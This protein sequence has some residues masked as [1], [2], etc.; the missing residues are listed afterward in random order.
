MNTTLAPIPDPG[1]S[2]GNV[3]AI[4]VLVFALAILYVHEQSGY[5]T[6]INETT[7]IQI[8][9]PLLIT[10]IIIFLYSA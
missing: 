1:V 3:V 4:V 7:L 8:I 5:N 6:E 9:V 10:V 2:F